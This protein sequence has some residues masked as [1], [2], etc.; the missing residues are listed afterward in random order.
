MD[1]DDLLDIISSLDDGPYSKPAP[2]YSF[3]EGENTYE[4]FIVFFK[5]NKV[6][7]YQPYAVEETDGV[8][9][10]LI[11]HDLRL[12]WGRIWNR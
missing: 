10:N 5:F 7:N 1:E 6:W 8:S 4:T 11:F 2:I 3:V 12:P 9:R